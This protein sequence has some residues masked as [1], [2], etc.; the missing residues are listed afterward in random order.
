LQGVIG[1]VGEVVVGDGVWVAGREEGVED[2][3]GEGNFGSLL[4]RRW[5]AQSFWMHWGYMELASGIG[6]SLE[7]SSHGNSPT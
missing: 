7:P 3:F 6:D 5:S 4:E 1:L 2:C